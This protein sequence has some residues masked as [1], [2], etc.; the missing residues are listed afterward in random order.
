M[1]KIPVQFPRYLIR[2]KKSE[3]IA[4]FCN[5]VKNNTDLFIDG[6]EI[7]LRYLGND[8][9]VVSVNAV[10]DDVAQGNISFEISE[11]DTFRIVEQDEEPEDKDVLWL[12]GEI[13]GDTETPIANNMRTEIDTLKKK[14][15]YLQDIVDK[16]EYSFNNALS[17]GNVKK[18]D[19]KFSLA[20]LA[21]QEAP[22]PSR[23]YD[24]GDTTIV[25]VKAF[26]GKYELEESDTLFTKQKYYLN[27]RA[28]NTAGNEVSTEGCFISFFLGEEEI[29]NG[30][31]YVEESGTTTL[32]VYLLTPDSASVENHYTIKFTGDEEP[33][34]YDEPTYHQ[35]IIKNAKTFDELT[36]YITNIAINEFCWCIEDNTLYFRGEASNHTIQ[37]FKINGGGILVKTEYFT[38]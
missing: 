36:K 5:Y 22:D 13:S 8:G 31:I 9:N 1:A 7:V 14:L 23:D 16:H 33:A 15:K 21:A 10:I 38:W 11:H 35:L 17:G 6:E 27:A 29:T 12:G 3:A 32:D 26:V 28:Y 34:Y 4:Q 24:T 25:S 20:N 30:I 2:K 37:L 19:A 18:N